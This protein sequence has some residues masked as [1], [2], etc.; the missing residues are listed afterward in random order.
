M[1]NNLPPNIIPELQIFKQGIREACRDGAQTIKSQPRKP[2]VQSSSSSTTTSPINNL[3]PTNTNDQEQP[4]AV[5]RAPTMVDRVQRLIEHEFVSA[6]PKQPL[7][8]SNKQQDGIEHFVINGSTVRRRATGQNPRSNINNKDIIIEIDQDYTDS[9][10]NREHRYA[11]GFLGE[12]ICRFE[13]TTNVNN[14]NGYKRLSTGHDES[15][16]EY[17]KNNVRINDNNH[18]DSFNETTYYT[19][20]E[21]EFAGSVE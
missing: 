3:L 10:S 14:T 16:F 18:D 13:P 1:N 12:A 11:S 4:P 5:V 8:T 6:H 17:N 9:S 15:Y 2:M 7:I 20:A 21:P 19:D